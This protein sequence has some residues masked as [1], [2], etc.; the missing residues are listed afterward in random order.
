MK[1]DLSNRHADDLPAPSNFQRRSSSP[2]PTRADYS[3]SRSVAPRPRPSAE[4]AAGAGRASK[5]W[6]SLSNGLAE[7]F[8][9][10]VD[11]MARDMVQEIQRAIPEYQQPLEGPFGEIMTQGIEQA[12]LHCVDTIKDPSAPA[13]NWVHVFRQLGKVEFNEGRSLDCLQ[14][15]YRVGGRV[16]WRHVA[17]FAHARGV[18]TDELCRAAEA[19]FAYV[20]EISAL[21]IQG[22]TE[23]RT[24]AAGMTARRK[25]RLLEMILASPP[26]S[27]QAISG[28]AAAARWTLPEWVTMVAL[29]PR[30]DQHKLITPAVHDEVLLDLESAEPCMLT[31]DPERDLGQ[32]ESELHGWRAAVGPTVRLSDARIS[33]RWARRALGLVHRGA[34]EDAPVTR[35]DDHLA[36]MWLLTDEFLVRQLSARSLAPFDGL[37]TKQRARL[38]ETL[39]AWLQSRGSAPELAAKLNVHPQTIR[40]RMHQLENLFGDKLTDADARLEME[41][42]LRAERLTSKP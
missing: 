38:S 14:T 23:A 42:A 16:A 21:S 28:L 39:L 17:E 24:R 25:R 6:A 20:D 22:Y 30:P 35:C 36:T 31:T 5:L 2:A 13:E 7:Q 41:I 9:P 3:R 26:A 18:S 27:P 1:A 4:P 40:Y 15:A 34:I 12:I 29:E 11:R 32:L 37:T 19:I 33:L 8:R 10:H